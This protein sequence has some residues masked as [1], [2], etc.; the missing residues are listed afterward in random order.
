MRK[1]FVAACLFAVASFAAA[2]MPEM[3]KP[4]PEQ[5]KMKY[6]V[7]DWKTEADVKA[8]PMGPGGKYTST[9]H[10]KMLGDFFVNIVSEG[11]V[12]GSNFT[13]NS[14]MAYDPKESAYTYDE[15]N[16]MGMHDVS[17]GTVSGDT[18]TWTS[19]MD[20]G[21]KTMH[22]RFTMNIVSPTSYT[23]KYEMSEDGKNWTSAMEGKSTKM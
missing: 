4:G 11:Q 6:F 2:Q 1:Q 23:F 20:M 16:S 5:A 18:W 21:G 22:G 7:G 17:K 15:Y 8:G 3:P 10:A 19:D 13:S 9:D 14:M 12:A